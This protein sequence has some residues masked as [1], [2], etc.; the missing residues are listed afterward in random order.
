MS[1]I[2]DYDPSAPA[3]KGSIYGL[4]F[5]EDSASVVIYPVPWDLTTSYQS[6]AA[7]GP[8]AILE[9]SG[10]LDLEMHGQEA[11]WKKGIWMASIDDT[12]QSR[13]AKLRPRV[14]K[15]LFDLENQKPQMDTSVAE[16]ANTDT[17][18]LN[19]KVKTDTTRFTSH[20]KKVGLLGGDHSCPLGF[21]Y[22]L[23]EVYEDFGILQIDAHMDLRKSYEGFQHSH[24][25]IMYNALQISAVSN[26][27]QVGIRD[28][29][30]EELEVAD[31]D[32]RVKTFYDRQLR[33][34]L[35]NGETWASVC[36][37]IVAQ[38]P[39]HVYVSFDIDGLNPHLCPGTGTPVPGGLEFEE[40]VFL[41][42]TLKKSGREIIGFDLCE[43]SPRSGDQEWNANVGARILY[44]LCSLL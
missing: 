32:V 10:Q 27:T 16:A 5:D 2:N 6:G 19:G 31:K 33:R 18:W 21:M 34:Q 44:F 7:E 9:A 28:Y 26:L 38:L 3:K 36:D 12:I 20:G 23:S 1:D 29:C 41:L 25:S 24:A 37:E 13:S 17:E 40:A 39:K 15:Y 22:T 35:F 4:P 43:V 30:E 8:Q 42:N 14:E 11:P